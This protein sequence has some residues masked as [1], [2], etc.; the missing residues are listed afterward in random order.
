MILGGFF[1]EAGAYDFQDQSTSLY[2]E[3]KYNWT[4]SFLGISF[5]GEIIFII[6]SRT[7]SV[8]LFVCREGSR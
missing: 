2:F 7:M 1:I 8:C 5:E 3:L 4:V 6:Q